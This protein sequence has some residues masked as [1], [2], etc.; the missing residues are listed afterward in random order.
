MFLLTLTPCWPA[1]AVFCSEQA[2]SDSMR[3]VS[4]KVRGVW[5]LQLQNMNAGMK[6]RRKKKRGNV[7]L[8]PTHAPRPRTLKERMKTF[9]QVIRLPL[10]YSLQVR[11][12]MIYIV[13]YICCQHI[14]WKDQHLIDSTTDCLCNQLDVSH[15]SEPKNFN[16]SPKMLP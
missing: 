14:R 9:A 11:L 13:F 3:G 2:S 6:R 1:S 8:P 10:T 4:R 12:A 16:F 7:Q 5:R 15:S